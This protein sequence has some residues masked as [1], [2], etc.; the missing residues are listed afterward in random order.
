VET[1]R[2]RTLIMMCQSSEFIELKLA[3]AVPAKFEQADGKIGCSGGENVICDLCT[4]FIAIA[5][6]P[7][8]MRGLPHSASRVK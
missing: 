7:S 4:G 2:R 8:F 5:N 6:T 3:L 1:N